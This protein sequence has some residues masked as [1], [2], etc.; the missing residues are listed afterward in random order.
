MKLRPNSMQS[1]R[2]DNP[3]PDIFVWLHSLRLGY[4]YRSSSNY[5]TSMP[6]DLLQ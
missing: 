2:N 5:G 1:P 4:V 3:I 6:S